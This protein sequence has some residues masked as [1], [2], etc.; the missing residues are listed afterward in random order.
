MLAAI[1]AHHFGATVTLSA[2]KYASSVLSMN[3]SMSPQCAARTPPVTNATRP[4]YASRR[5]ARGVTRRPGAPASGDPLS[6][7]RATVSTGRSRT[8]GVHIH[9]PASYDRSAPVRANILT[10]D[11]PGGSRSEI[12][13]D[14][15]LSPECHGVPIRQRAHE[16]T[17]TPP[18]WRRNSPPPASQRDAQCGCGGDDN[19]VARAAPPLLSRAKGGLGTARSRRPAIV[20]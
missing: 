9:L 19:D 10:G 7:A 2:C 1:E 8:W 14:I 6:R 4:T 18:P 15:A 20:R 16:S 17:A 11:V 3:R 12:Q 5:R 13:L